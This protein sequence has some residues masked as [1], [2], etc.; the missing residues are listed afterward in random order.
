MVVFSKS[1]FSLCRRCF[2][3][4]RVFGGQPCLK[5]W[6]SIS[7]GKTAFFTLGG[8]FWEGP[9]KQAESKKEVFLTTLQNEVNFLAKR[10][11]GFQ[12]LFHFSGSRPKISSF[13]VKYLTFSRFSS[14]CPPKKVSAD[15]FF[16]WSRFR[17][18]ENMS[19]LRGIIGCFSLFWRYWKKAFDRGSSKKYV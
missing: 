9:W 18:F 15:V 12:P 17:E 4:S 6:K 3:K 2:A 13:L 8:R 10:V 7:H 1:R 14:K 19:I 5:T 11:S 16:W